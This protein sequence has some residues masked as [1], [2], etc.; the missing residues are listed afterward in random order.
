M[1]SGWMR[2]VG[3]G[4]G[5]HLRKAVGRDDGRADGGWV[6]SGWLG[7]GGVAGYPGRW[8]QEDGGD[9]R[10]VGGGGVAMAVARG[11][12]GAGAGSR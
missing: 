2:W 12:A 8:G 3:C 10:T 4:S 5:A 11:G 9:R 7:H 6:D 1:G